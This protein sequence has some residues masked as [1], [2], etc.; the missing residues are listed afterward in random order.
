M[1]TFMG[2]DLA[3]IIGFSIC[4]S[5]LL[6]AGAASGNPAKNLV[7]LK[8]SK[9]K[10][11]NYLSHRRNRQFLRVVDVLEVHWQT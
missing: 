7:K 4:K 11:L 9:K 2:S 1:G 10:F 8:Y 3:I 6:Y 5:F